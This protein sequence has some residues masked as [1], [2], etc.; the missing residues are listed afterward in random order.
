MS[1]TATLIA[2]ASGLAAKVKVKDIIA[3][4]Q[5]KNSE[6]EVE[7][8]LKRLRKLECQLCEAENQRDAAEAQL[9]RHRAEAALDQRWRE[10]VAQAQLMNAQLNAAMAQQQAMQAQQQN[11]VQPDWVFYQQ[12]LGSFQQLGQVAQQALLG[13][14]NLDSAHWRDWVCT[15]IPDRASA[16][17]GR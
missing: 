8:L 9:E 12:Q 16:L 3:S 4:D 1:I 14:Q 10:H 6:V 7:R 5:E 11:G 2:F 17:R 13:A 15:C